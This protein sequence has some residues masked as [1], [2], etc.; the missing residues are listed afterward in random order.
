MGF[1][2]FYKKS[3][4]LIYNGYNNMTKANILIIAI[5]ISML[6]LS[7]YADAPGCYDYYN[8]CDSICTNNNNCL[9]SSIQ[10]KYQKQ[11]QYQNETKP[12]PQNQ[13]QYQ[14]E[15]KLKPH[16]L[17]NN[18]VDICLKNISST[19]ASACNQVGLI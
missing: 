7:S 3:F 18:C 2:V 6:T 9:S 1:D 8:T 4:N 16:P 19:D 13:S 5:S 15:T 10:I 11:L 14:N 17:F 12:H